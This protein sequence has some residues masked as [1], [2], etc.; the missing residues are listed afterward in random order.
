M[1]NYNFVSTLDGLNNI[2]ADDVNSDN[3][4][5]DYLTV[6]INSSVPLV[7]PHTANTNQIASCA[8]V[9]NAFI[10]NLLDY[11]KLNPSPSQTFTGSNIFPT[12]TKTDNSTLVATTAYVKNN[13]LDYVTLASVQTITGNKILNGTT[14]LNNLFVSNYVDLTLTT[15]ENQFYGD[16]YGYRGV[17]CQNGFYVKNS[18][19]AGATTYALI[20][21]TG[22]ISTT[23]NISAQSI[24]LPNNSISD[25]YLSS[26]VVL[27]NGTNNMTGTNNFNTLT[28]T[29]L[30]QTTGT[31]NTTLANTA[32]VQNSLTNSLTEYVKLNNGGSNQT[33]SGTGQTIINSPTTFNDTVILNNSTSLNNTI[34]IYDGTNATQ[35]DQNGVNLTVYSTGGIKMGSSFA[36]N[37]VCSSNRAYLQ[38]SVG[39]TIDM[40]GTQATIGGSSV[41]KITTQPASGSNTNEIATTQWSKT[42]LS[43]YAVLNGSNTFTGGVNFNAGFVQ[44]DIGGTGTSTSQYQTGVTYSITNNYNNGSI[45]LNTRNASGVRQDGVYALNGNRAGLQG[46]LNNTLEIEGTIC[47][48]NCGT[49]KF[50]APLRCN[51]YNITTVPT[52]TNYDIGYIWSIPG[53][54]FTNWISYTTPNNIYTLVWDGSGDKTLGVWQVDIVLCTE[55]TASPNSN[56]IWTTVN[57]TSGDLTNTCTQAF[58]A[59]LFGTTGVQIMRLSFVL[60][61]TVIPSTYYL[62][63]KRVA[64]IGSGLVANTT[65]S[66]ITFTR[67][68]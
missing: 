44:N 13:L 16:I 17:V 55:C 19:G 61:V 54:S 14:T 52:K 12:Q 8:F 64:G 18:P 1:S 7:T 31:N 46:D 20:D 66:K 9:Q 48:V 62:N 2:N 4:T 45:R 36:D 11:A 67:I 34:T 30:T 39:N 60:N 25:S 6:N 33:L 24:T 51:Y 57:A 29:C 15:Y 68:S 56:L 49:I 47:T 59:S 53:S 65:N 40:N 26:N 38:G 43:G 50:N 3:I 22:N 23:S 41:P 37:I 5:T 63:Y 58:D 42:Q 28:N 35:F 10:N 32:F 21:S 27:K